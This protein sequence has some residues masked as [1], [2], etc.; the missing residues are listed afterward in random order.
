MRQLA[1]RSPGCPPP[2]IVGKQDQKTSSKKAD[3]GLSRGLE[4]DVSNR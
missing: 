1:E 4:G 2:S 3:R